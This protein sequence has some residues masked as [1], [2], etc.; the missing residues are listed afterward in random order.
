MEAYQVIKAHQASARIMYLIQESATSNFK[1][2]VTKDMHS[3]GRRLTNLQAGNPRELSIAHT[4]EFEADGEAYK[5]EQGMLLYFSD[6]TSGEWIMN[7]EG[8]HL[9]ATANILK[10]IKMEYTAL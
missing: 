5:L 2:G 7:S 10:G 9:I 3:L 4:W 6:D 8:W 1:V